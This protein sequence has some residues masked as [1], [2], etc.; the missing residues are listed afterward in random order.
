M[1]LVIDSGNTRLKWALADSLATT[2]VP[3]WIAAGTVARDALD[4]LRTDWQGLPAPSVVVV[5]NVAGAAVAQGI[6]ACLPAIDPAGKGV[7]FWFAS[8]PHRAGVRN[9]YARPAQLGADRWAAVLGAWQRLHATALV[10]S[11][12]TAT[13]IDAMTPDGEQAGGLFQGGMIMPGLAMM[14]RALGEGTADLGVQ[15][16]VVSMWPRATAD[17]IETGCIE[18][19][20]GAIERARQRLGCR[21][22][23]ILTGGAA[24]ALAPF[25]EAPLILAPQLVLE[26]LLVAAREHAG[27]GTAGV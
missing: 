25:I 11:A 26:G 9:A 5:A 12:G 7:P 14:R 4:T 8:E 17:A 10:V 16:G 24:D 23:V 27:D 15:Q 2:S 21:V 13:T 3:A 1:I 19:Q 18:A 22:P 20:I 6:R